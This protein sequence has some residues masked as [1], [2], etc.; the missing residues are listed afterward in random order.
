MSQSH[1]VNS[2]WT[3]AVRR[4]DLSQVTLAASPLPALA[5]GQALLRVDRVGI[6]ANNIT[7]GVLGESFRYWEFFPA[8]AR[9][10]DARWGLPP[11]WG[12]CEV[13]AS[14]VAGVDE[15]QR[16][17]GYLPPATHLIVTPGRVDEQGF[18]DAGP[19]RAELPSPYNAYRRTDGDPAYDRAREDLLVLFRPLFFT[20]FMLADQL[21]DHDFYRADVLVLSSAS[22][23]TAYAAAY[24]LRGKGP[25]L[26]GLTSAGNVEFTRSLGCYDEVL[27]YQ[28]VADLDR[29][30]ATAYLDLSGR[31]ELRVALRAHLGD[32]LV[33][34]IAVGLTS[35]TPNAASANEV[36]FA[37]VQMRKRT[38]DWGRAGLDA[39]F[40]DAW[41]R[42]S[43]VVENWV[44]VSVGHGPEA[45]RDA[46]LDVL[47]GHTPPRTAH[48]ISL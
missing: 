6:T 14:T 37:P 4:D 9:G 15:G 11:V 24:E 17:Y 33:R 18:R 1:T 2:P 12:F 43:T 48:V 28:Q 41:R 27:S 13:E 26:V 40:S 16:L 39:R 25:K 3:M 31:A 46:W 22:S 29:S 45:L 35:Q 44:D 10:L 19:H 23:K 38:A 21:I 30:R 8:A 32:R 20:S 36:F 5:D 34:D 42:F 7:Y 47:G